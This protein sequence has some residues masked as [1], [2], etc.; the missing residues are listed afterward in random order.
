MSEPYYGSVKQIAV[1]GHKILSLSGVKPM[2]PPRGFYMVPVKQ[3][4]QQTVFP[5]PSYFANIAGNDPEKPVLLELRFVPSGLRL[6]DHTPPLQDGVDVIHPDAFIALLMTI[7]RSFEEI[8]IMTEMMVSKIE[9]RGVRYSSVVAPAS[10]GILLSN[11]INRHRPEIIGRTI[12]KGKLQVGADGQAIMGSPKPWIPDSYGVP[13]SSG[14]S[15]AG[16]QQKIYIDPVDVDALR[17]KQEETGVGAL[18]VDDAF[19]S[20]GTLLA[21][22]G[23]MERLGVAVAGIVTILNENIPRQDINGI[24]FESLTKLPLSAQTAEGLVP[25]YGT[26]DGLSHWY[27][28]HASVAWN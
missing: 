27:I 10:L 2:L 22:I 12:Q 21:G 15:I 3:Q 20:G 6:G 9:A 24:P 25:I 14:T 17:R 8:D 4:Q 11:G 5:G 1:P 7:E 18:M 19:L 26:Y 28:P 16:T 23:L 13:V